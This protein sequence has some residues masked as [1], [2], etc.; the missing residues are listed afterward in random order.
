MKGEASTGKSP[1]KNVAGR[2]AVVDSEDEKSEAPGKSIDHRSRFRL[3]QEQNARRL[4]MARQQ[5]EMADNSPK[6]DDG[7]D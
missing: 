4:M 2:E 6:K 5:K 7:G 3:W 1:E